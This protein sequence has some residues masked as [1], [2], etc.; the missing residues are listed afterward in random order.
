MYIFNDSC[1]CA[2][3]NRRDTKLPI[4]SIFS[5]GIGMPR[6]RHNKQIICTK[7]LCTVDDQ[8]LPGTAIEPQSQPIFGLY[9]MAKSVSEIHHCKLKGEAM[10]RTNVDSKT[11]CIFNTVRRR[12]YRVRSLTYNFA[13]KNVCNI[14]CSNFFPFSDFR[15][16]ELLYEEAKN[17]VLRGRYVLE[18]AHLLML[19]GIQARIE[20]GH[21]DKKKHTIN[22]FRKKQ[23]NF[24]PE[25]V[26]CK[27]KW[28]YWPPG[29]TPSSESRLLEQYKRVPVT[30]SIKKLM[31]KYLEFCW[32]LPYYG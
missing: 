5:G 9:G 4:E 8:P 15:I 6:D 13:I 2:Y 26:P 21:Y 25:H 7:Y 20:L 29:R 31:R 18:P 19:G 28:N 16:I 11:K 22:F 27:A 32:A 17:N 1:G 10:G 30:A 24:L 14:F 23:Y 12:A 3:G